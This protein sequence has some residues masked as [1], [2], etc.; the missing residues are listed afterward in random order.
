[1]KRTDRLYPEVGVGSGPC[2]AVGQAGG[3]L[4]TRIVDL[5]GLGGELSTGLARWRKP[6]AAHESGEDHDRSRGQPRAGR[7]LSG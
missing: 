3:V 4:L 2:R 1:M 5:A 6:F 7:G